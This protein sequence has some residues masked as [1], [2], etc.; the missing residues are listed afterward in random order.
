M[1]PQQRLEALLDRFTW[2]SDGKLDSYHIMA[3]TGPVRGDCDDFAVTLVFEMADRKP[4]R[5]M[6]WILTGHVQFW[7]VRDPQGERHIALYVDGVGFTD[8]QKRTW[9]DSNA[10]HAP[11]RRLP[12]LIPVCKL[13]VGMFDRT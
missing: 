5:F 10:P 4:L 9:T 2:E 8:N 7:L 3:A 1:T 6:R 11:L 13:F 12:R